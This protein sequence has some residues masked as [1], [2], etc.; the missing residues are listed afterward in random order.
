MAG[1]V[2]WSA[3]SRKL[4]ST[5]QRYS[6]PASFDKARFVKALEILPEPFEQAVT[7]RF[8]EVRSSWI[9]RFRGVLFR[10]C[11]LH[12]FLMDFVR[13]LP[14]FDRNVLKIPLGDRHETSD[15]GRMSVKAL[16]GRNAGS[17][18]FDPPSF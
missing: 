14:P 1:R 13:L 9:L 15:R 2:Y 7:Y 6:A 16:S 4:S 11:I 5:F 12:S 18:S 3:F 8:A 17:S 10:T